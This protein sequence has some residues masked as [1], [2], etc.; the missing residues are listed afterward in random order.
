MRSKPLAEVGATKLFKITKILSRYECLDEI[1]EDH[2]ARESR[3]QEILNAISA[4]PSA[5]EN[6][7]ST[8]GEVLEPILRVKLFT[9]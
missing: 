3:V 8:V 1:P 5:C 7:N 4:F 9:S 2:I 6:P